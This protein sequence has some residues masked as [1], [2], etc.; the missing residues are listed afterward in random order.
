MLGVARTLL[1][2]GVVTGLA[3]V[4]RSLLSCVIRH[5][6]VYLHQVSIGAG[7]TFLYIP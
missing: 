4:A 2:F 5:N 7:H 6:A 1:I 3:V